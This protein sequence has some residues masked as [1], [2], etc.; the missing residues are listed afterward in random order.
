MSEMGIQWLV[1]FRGFS[2]EFYCL[3]FSRLKVNCLKYWVDI[4]E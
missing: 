1:L 4:F 2:I 3:A